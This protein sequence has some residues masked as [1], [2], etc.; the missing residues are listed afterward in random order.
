MGKGPRRRRHGLNACRQGRAGGLGLALSALQLLCTYG[1]LNDKNAHRVLGVALIVRRLPLHACRVCSR[2]SFEL[3]LKCLRLYTHRHGLQLTSSIVLG[4][5]HAVA[6][7][8]LGRPAVFEARAG[9]AVA[10]TSSSCAVMALLPCSPCRMSYHLVARS[11]QF[12]WSAGVAPQA[13]GSWAPIQPFPAISRSSR[14]L[15]QQRS[16]GAGLNPSLRYKHTC[17][18][19]VRLLRCLC[20]ALQFWH[21]HACQQVPQRHT[22]VQTQPSAIHQAFC[23]RC[24]AAC[25]GWQGGMCSSLCDCGTGERKPTIAARCRPRQ[26]L[27][28]NTPCHRLCATRTP[29]N[30]E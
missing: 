3:T 2:V 19:D 24:T 26:P 1:R 6:V 30:P 15:C 22:T 10:G 23:P 20:A 28:C 16:P 18:S 29:G 11:Y 9:S 7:G 14:C 27:V 4:R 21:A 17:R 5:W 25:P 12:S 8:M 13:P